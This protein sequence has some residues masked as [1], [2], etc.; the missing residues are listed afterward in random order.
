MWNLLSDLRIWEIAATIAWTLFCIGSLRAA[1]RTRQ[2]GG[3]RG[4]GG[5]G[6]ISY[7]AIWLGG[8]LATFVLLQVVRIAPTTTTV[9]PP[10]SSAAHDDAGKMPKVASARD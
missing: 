6:V 8:I 3:R 2:G 4:G 5:S 1:Q 7:G 9:Q 10:A